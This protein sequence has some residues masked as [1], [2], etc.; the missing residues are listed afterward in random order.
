[1]LKIISF[2]FTLKDAPW[3]GYCKAIAPE[4]V[5]ASTYLK[6]KFSEVVFAKVDITSEKELKKRFNIKEWP[7]LKYFNGSSTPT[8]AINL[9]TSGEICLWL[10]KNG[11]GPIFLKNVEQLTNFKDSNDVVV[12]GLFDSLDNKHVKTLNDMSRL[13]IFDLVYFAITTKKSIYTELNLLT[14]NSSNSNSSSSEHIVLFK[15]FDEG[16]NDFEGEFVEDDVKR[17]IQLN[18]LE[19]I[20]E[21]NQI[22]SQKLFGGKIKVHNFLFASKQ[23]ESFETILSEFKEAA[24]VFRGRAIFVLVDSDVDEN[25]RVLEFFGLKKEDSPTIRL[26]NNTLTDV[27]KF[28][29]HETEITASVVTKF[30][31][32]FFDDKLKKDMLSQELP[33]DWDSQPVKV[34]VGNNFEKIARDRSKSVLVEFYAPWCGAC[35]QFE[36][37]YLQ[38][39]ENFRYQNDYVVAKIDAT[40]NE[41]ENIRVENYP[42]IKYIYI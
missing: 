9:R 21:Y 30:V 33:A 36:P 40:A 41:V 11:P 19:L 26:I 31:Q 5:K 15:K 20:T 38:L 24:K 23:N 34:L 35:K 18:Q 8:D 13:D 1:L 7:F 14:D 39:A 10:K 3:C 6:E 37:T 25:G 17:F 29:P 12:V 28:K 22:T 42:T 2:Y 27:V 16:R 4:Y 32:D